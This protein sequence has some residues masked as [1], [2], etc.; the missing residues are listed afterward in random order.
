MRFFFYGTLRDRDVRAFVLGPD[1]DTWTVTAAVLRGWRAAVVAG[2]TYPAAVPRRGAVSDGIVIDGIGEGAL[3]R[4]LA[5][6]GP[7][8]LLRRLDVE[9]AGR[10]R[11]C[12][13]A[14]AFVFA[15][16]RDCVVSPAAWRFDE[17]RRRHRMSVLRAF[18]AGRRP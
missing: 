9:V 2:R 5:Y 15:A 3:S 18:R 11:F 8:Y 7:E 1:S 4:L 17:W 10:G 16:S 13:T 14:P 6:E 12:E